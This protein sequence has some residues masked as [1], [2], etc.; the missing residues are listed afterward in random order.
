MRAFKRVY[1]AE[2][3]LNLFVIWYNFIRVHQGIKMTPNEK[4][5]IDLRLG[6]N[7][8]LSLISLSVII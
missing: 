4:A 2:A 6:Q 1:S 5:G 8:W 3:I 7:K